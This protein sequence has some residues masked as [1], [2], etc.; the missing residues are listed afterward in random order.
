MTFGL[1]PL[2][3][4]RISL[5]GGFEVVT[6]GQSSVQVLLTIPEI[7]WEA[8]LGINLAWKGFRKDAPV[9]QVA[10]ARSV[11]VPELI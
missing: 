11:T 2:A 3:P 7:V 5:L 10:S 8:S 6:D 1:E 4:P 9:L